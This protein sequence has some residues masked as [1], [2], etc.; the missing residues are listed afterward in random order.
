M[1]QAL[2]M[3]TL[4][5]S[6]AC[7]ESRG[8]M[9]PHYSKN[10]LSVEITDADTKQRIWRIQSERPY[11]IETLQFG[12]VP[13]GFKQVYPTDGSRPKPVKYIRLKVRTDEGWLEQDCNLLSESR[14]R[15]G[16]YRAGPST[17]GGQ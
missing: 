9:P 17:T 13:A 6:V 11:D 10:V 3:S 8:I 16:Y 12:T 2:M 15:C 1:L 14:V 7:N 4:W 5:L